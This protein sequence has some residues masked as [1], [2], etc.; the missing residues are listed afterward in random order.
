MTRAD[1][2]G[3]RCAEMAEAMTVPDELRRYVTRLFAGIQQPMRPDDEMIP[4]RD[5]LESE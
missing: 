1:A 2:E 3:F 5:D 4:G